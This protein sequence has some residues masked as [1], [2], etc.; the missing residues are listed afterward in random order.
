MTE[1]IYT[2]RRLWKDRWSTA[3]AILVSALGAGLNTALFAIVYGVLLRPLPYSDADRLA[4]MDVSVSVASLPEWR[5]ALPAFSSV[6]GYASE[7]FTV[8]GISEPRFL[9]VAVVD[10]TFFATLGTTPAVGRV[11]AT[12]DGPAVA[13]VS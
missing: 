12:D 10:E 6:S 5:A 9:P 13:V 4:V 8:R 2:G 11:F 1:I 7:G 3:A